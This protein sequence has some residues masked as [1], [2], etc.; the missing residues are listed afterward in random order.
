MLRSPK[1]S[2]VVMATASAESGAFR[3]PAGRG[4]YIMEITF[5]GYYPYYQDIDI[6]KENPQLS[7][8]TIFLA[9]NPKMLDDVVIEAKI[10]D[11]L[12]KGDTIEYNA[13]AYMMNEHALLKDL[14]ENI[15]GAQIDEN[16]DIKIN[17]KKVNKILIDGKEFFG[18]D[19]KTALENLP[20]NMI[21]KLQLYNKESETSK[22]T[23][24]KDA[25]ENPVLD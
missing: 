1:D 21:N 9:E 20:A 8:D 13:G 10:P 6:T 18:S 7:V 3:I 24:I 12:V 14:I 16:G 5:L 19:I 2:T 4:R 17:G 25:E 23:G 22:I 15:P 11:I